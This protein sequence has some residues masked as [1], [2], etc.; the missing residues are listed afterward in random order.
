[1]GVRMKRGEFSKWLAQ[2]DKDGN[3][4]N[5]QEVAHNAYVDDT[6]GDDLPKNF[7]WAAT[8]RTKCNI[9]Y[10]RDQANCGSCWVIIFRDR[11]TSM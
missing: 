1:M 3:M 11:M 9:D 4:K 8:N 7:S 2:L 5:E 6:K 10:I